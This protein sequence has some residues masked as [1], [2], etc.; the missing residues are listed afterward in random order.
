MSVKIKLSY[1]LIGIIFIIIMLN[2]AKKK[3]KGINLEAIKSDTSSMIT[4]KDTLVIPEQDTFSPDTVVYETIKIVDTIIL[5]TQETLYT[6]TELPKESLEIKIDTIEI[7]MPDS[8]KAFWSVQIGAFLHENNAQCF[9]ERAKKTLENV[10]IEYVPPYWKVRVGKFDELSLAKTF[11]DSLRK[12]GYHD[13][14][15]ILCKP[16]Q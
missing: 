2:C 10:F 8:Q 14:F 16:K 6:K 12:S 1:I 9:S 5:T 13:A 4:E 7:P 15:I 11:C 3:P